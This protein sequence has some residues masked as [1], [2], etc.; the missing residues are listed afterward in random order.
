MSVTISTRSVI[1]TAKNAELVSDEKAKTAS[2]KSLSKPD[3]VSQPTK[4]ESVGSSAITA[5]VRANAANPS[6]AATAHHITPSLHIRD[7]TSGSAG[8]P[9]GVLEAA[10]GPSAEGAATKTAEAAIN[11]RAK[12]PAAVVTAAPSV[13]QV[14][15]DST[16]G[17]AAEKKPVEPEVA[18][19][20]P[21]V[22]ARAP[23]AD[24]DSWGCS[25]AHKLGS[26]HRLEQLVDHPA[27]PPAERRQLGPVRKHV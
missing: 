23:T 5:D 22:K 14:T 2:S 24:A 8:Q 20:E 19:P 25:H 26:A 1:R 17:S 11:D 7:S 16:T 4:T 27:M 15:P 18:A 12:T 21:A 9:D 6:D 13:D 10:G 3:S